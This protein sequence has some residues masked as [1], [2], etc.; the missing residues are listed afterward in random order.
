M[1]KEN[2]F[3]MPAVLKQS[4]SEKESILNSVRSEDNE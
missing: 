2:R 4:I 1:P 3:L